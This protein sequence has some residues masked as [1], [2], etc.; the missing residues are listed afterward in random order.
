MRFGR[1]VWVVAAGALAVAAWQATRFRQPVAVKAQEAGGQAL[2]IRFGIDGKADVDWSG[3]ISPAPRGLR[4]WQFGAGEE[5]SGS[6]W[7]CQTKREPYWD[8]PYEKTMQPTSRRERVAAK[9]LVVEFD[10]G[11]SFQ[12]QTAQGS[13][14]I[15]GGLEAW[16]AARM[17]LG[18]RV[19]VRMVPAA[20]AVTSG[21][22]A[23]D[24]PSMLEARDGNLWVAWQE[25]EG[26]G[27]RV[28]V[29]RNRQA[30]EE[31]APAGGDHFRTA[32]GEDKGGG[33]W[34]V[35]SAQVKGDFDLHGRR[36]DGKQWSA[37]HR[38]TESGGS[39]IYHTLA[40]GQDGQMYLAWQSA[41]NGNFDIYA[42]RFDGERWSQELRVSTTPANDW[43]P[44]LAAA[45]GG[46]VA[47]LW[48]TYERG[49][50]DIAMK[51]WRGSRLGSLRRI[52]WSEAMES[53]VSGQYDKQGRLWMAW[54]E[55]DS[56][57]GKDY[58]QGIEDNGRGLLVRRQTRVAALV[59]GHLMEPAADL[60]AAVPG[61]LRQVFHNPKLVLD[62]DGNPAVFFHYRVNLPQRG[63][64][65]ESSR[66]MWRI[67]MTWLD[68]SRW[69]PMVEFP[70]GWGR[71]DSPLAAVWTG[72]KDFAVAWTSEG[73]QWPSGA[74]RE[75]NLMEARAPGGMAGGGPPLSAFQ[76]RRESLK[77]SH[78]REAEDVARV[79][80]YRS[81]V[82][83]R[84]YR[85]ARGDIHRHT[86]I[87]WDGNRDGSLEDSY[88]YALDAVAFDFLGVCDHQAGN[89]IPYNWW[90]I[91]KAADLYA[92]RGRFAPLYSYERSLTWPNGHRN[93]VFAKRGRPVLEIGEAERRGK[94]GAGKLYEY[95]RRFGGLTSSHTSATGAG[96]DWRD[97]NE[98]LE[99][100]VEIYQGYRR[101]Y[102]GPGTPRSPAAGE[103]ARYAGGY[104]WNAWAK[105]I[106]M[107]VQSS[108]DHVSTHISY[109]AVYVETLDRESIV[110]AMKA[111]R[112]YAATDNLI[113]DLR[114]G[115]GMMGVAMAAPPRRRLEAYVRGTARLKHVE[116]V[117]NNRVIYTA[118]GRGPELRFAFT[119]QAAG[120]G[121]SYYYIRAE[122]QDGQLCWSSPVWVR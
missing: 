4:S 105:G 38:L 50:Y 66:A 69:A 84:T 36:W 61:E 102:E 48:D 91:Q 106:K 29:R 16:K 74:P 120:E 18:G 104:V 97:S 56:N 103:E 31:V 51:E 10:A 75:Q 23:E 108:S 30:P 93:V 15:A 73:R 119:D 45:P 40:Y 63:G 71:I 5:V 87:S 25:H 58:G 32:L 42:K 121:E 88:R 1:H 64:G 43:E 37:I 116:V 46:G 19:E 49:N 8:T 57:W 99:P 65:E 101:N 55:G 44:A 13:F 98:E 95:L 22:A 47:I 21:P 20:Q 92:I 114:M 115:N 67:G 77:P 94:E 34:V 78:A 12:V 72:R 52:T 26:S 81:R 89:M 6:S 113:V 14:T 17:F 76:H 79:R 112:T 60:G 41:R 62:G 110:A 35:W 2:L 27:D 33:I 83:G 70:E 11:Q 111:R 122:Q 7:K 117:K 68:G 54:D 28:L 9:G 59:G 96:T 39:D 24:Y 3:S 109:A 107:G 80:A 118:A 86:D 100:V 85:I 53:R 82:G 90:R